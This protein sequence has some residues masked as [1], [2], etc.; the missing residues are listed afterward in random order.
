MKRGAEDLF[1]EK[2]KVKERLLSV[3]EGINYG[4]ELSRSIH[5]KTPQDDEIQQSL[6]DHIKLD[7]AK[8]YIADLLSEKKK[9]EEEENLEIKLDKDQVIDRLKQKLRYRDLKHLLEFKTNSPGKIEEALNSFKE[10]AEKFKSKVVNENR[11]GT[12]FDYECLSN[13]FDT[14]RAGA[15][16]GNENNDRELLFKVL[17]SLS[18]IIQLDFEQREKKDTTENGISDHLCR[19]ALG[20]MSPRDKRTLIEL[21]VNG[22]ED[23][24]PAYLLLRRTKTLLQREIRRSRLDSQIKDHEASKIV[25]AQKAFMYI[26]LDCT[27]KFSY[28]AFMEFKDIRA[29]LRRLQAVSQLQCQKLDLCRI[30]QLK[31]IRE[32]PANKVS[33]P[34][35]G[36]KYFIEKVKGIYES[37]IFDGRTDIGKK[38]GANNDSATDGGLE[39]V[40]DGIATDGVKEE[41]VIEPNFKDKN[42]P[43]I[44]EDA[45][46]NIMVVGGGPAGLLTTIH[47][48]ENCKAV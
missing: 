44:Y 20:F 36:K 27:R 9:K 14:V 40:E 24:K 48:L 32:T 37:H 11:I 26:E 30:E 43:I 23:S 13:L 5:W 15:L 22:F 28:N 6:L 45:P 46:Q 38:D 34:E 4:Y 12:R 8:L 33:E 18:E 21:V 7:R 42:K 35:H 16:G 47:C 3:E 25:L 1:Q 17:E 19:R 39:G 29:N 2:Q 31:K 41:E 10:N